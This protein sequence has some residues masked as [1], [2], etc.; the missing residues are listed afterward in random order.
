MIVD[1]NKLDL[2]RAWKSYKPGVCWETFRSMSFDPRFET[3]D[4]LVNFCIGNKEREM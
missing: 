2:L 1:V 3:I 4:E